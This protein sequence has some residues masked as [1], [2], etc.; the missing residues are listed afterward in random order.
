MP[1]NDL[2]AQHQLAQHQAQNAT[3]DEERERFA[4]LESY[5]AAK[6]DAWRDA[7]DLPNQG[8]PNDAAGAN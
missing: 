6:I 2:L 1:M 8:W 7:L 5:Y 4:D 3:T